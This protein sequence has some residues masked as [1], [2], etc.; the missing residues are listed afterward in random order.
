MPTGGPLPPERAAALIARP[1]LV[2][3]RFGRPLVWF[4]SASSGLLLRLIGAR[5]R[6]ETGVSNEEISLLMAQGAEAGVFHR[7]EQVLVANVLRLDEQ[8]VVAIMTCKRY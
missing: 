1:M 8:P 3:A 5:R 4:L 6:P 7:S 2:L